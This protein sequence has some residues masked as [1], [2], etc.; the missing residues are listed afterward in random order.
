MPGTQ[1]KVAILAL[2]APG[3]LRMIDEGPAEWTVSSAL[4]PLAPATTGQ[5]SIPSPRPTYVSLIHPARL[6]PHSTSEMGIVRFGDGA[7]HFSLLREFSPGVTMP[8]SEPM[9]VNQKGEDFVRP[10]SHF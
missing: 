10:R 7:A 5:Q 3:G 1:F 6:R 9:R 2:S 4:D 8:R